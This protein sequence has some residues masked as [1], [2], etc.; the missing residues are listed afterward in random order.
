MKI[1]KGV[2]RIVLWS[3]KHGN[4]ESEY[5]DAYDW[6]RNR[7]KRYAVADG[8]TETSF[9]RLWASILANAFV[10]N[11]L[12]NLEEA[13]LL[14]LVE[15][16][17]RKVKERTKDAPLP[18]YAEAKLEE[19]AFSSLL[20]L[21][22]YARK[23]WDCQFV[24][25]S[26][27]FQIRAG[28]LVRK[29]PYEQPTEFN[30]RPALISTNLSRNKDLKLGKEC[31]DWKLGDYFLLMTDALAQ[32]LLSD[33]TIMEHCVKVK[34]PDDFRVWIDGLRTEQRCRND[35][36]TLLRVHITHP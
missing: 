20:G 27:L 23:K 36:I 16:W 29:I 7:T 19:G 3:P 17:D 35:D 10:N 28:E 22:I 13:F 6:S 9:S 25:D 18:W 32:C 21:A 2:E 8:A 1:M 11:K 14:P 26:C 34:S 30:N 5:E 4:S 12:P 33:S 24:G 15:E 31:G